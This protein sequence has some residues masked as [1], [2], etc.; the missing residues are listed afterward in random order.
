MEINYKL[1]N[2]I[3]ETINTQIKENNPPETKITFDRLI[4]EGHSEFETKQLIGQCLA[5]EIFNILKF[6]KQF[7]N[8]R[9]IKNLK[10]L[11]NLDLE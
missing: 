2:Q 8:E 10:A 11:P 9:Y 6:K 3:F 5:I 4:K 7:D 1:R